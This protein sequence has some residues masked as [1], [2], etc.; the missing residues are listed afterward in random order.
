MILTRQTWFLKWLVQQLSMILA[1]R[2]HRPSAQQKDINMA[3]IQAIAKI[4]V[5]ILQAPLRIP[6]AV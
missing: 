6:L 1:A 4:G 5:A 3:I 2:K